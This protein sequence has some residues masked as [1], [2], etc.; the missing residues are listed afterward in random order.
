L[1]M[2]ET[3]RRQFMQTAAASSALGLAGLD[4]LS[5]LPAV[6]A[7]AAKLDPNV[8]KL[9]AEIEPLVRL[10]EETSRDRLLEEVADR[11]RKGT[12]YREVL[13]ALLLAGVRNV[14]PRPSVGFKFHAVLVVNSAHIASLSS[15]DADRWLPIFWALDHFKDSQAKNIVER[16]GWRMP[17]VD[18]KLV[19]PARKA[20]AAFVAA[21]ESWDAEAVDPA[22]AGLVRTGGTDEVWELF[23]KYAT[24]DFRAIGHKIIFA[25]NA[26]RT[27]DTIGWQHAEPVLRSLA[28]ALMSYSGDN[29]AKSDDAADRPGR[30]NLQLAKEIPE[31]WREGKIDSAATSDLLATLREG[32]EEEA[33]K[34]CVDLLKKGISPQSLWDAILAGAG[35]LLMRRPGIVPLHAVTTSNAIRYAYETSGDDQTRRWLL[36]QNAAFLALFR[37]EMVGREKGKSL[38][39]QP[40]DK[41][42]ALEP[43]KSGT[44][45]IGE[46]LA[47]V[48]KDRLSAARKALTYLK[49]NPRP[50]ELIDA[51]RVLIFLKGND[52]HDYKFSSAVLE[53]YAHVSPEW[54]D[55]FLASSMFQLRGSAGAD[56]ALVKRTRAALKG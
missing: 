17:P 33:P 5:G 34:K 9:D 20:R 56:N 1:I 42:E 24:R 32:S 18:E 48:S 38:P 26:K 37:Q 39:A 2:A 30:K 7:D 52:A 40:I 16:K 4:F 53:D 12:T 11:I 23:W 31:N 43:T 14:E 36:L 21:L 8:V 28:Y 44:E 50:K 13:A 27:L 19:P 25:A 35:E 22:I 6:S 49:A 15:P 54:R 10:L 3:T 51:A 46:I 55:R 47:E 45:G 29:P 41:L